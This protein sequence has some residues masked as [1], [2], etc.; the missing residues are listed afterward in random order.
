MSGELIRT[1]HSLEY[2]V[3]LEECVVYF[4]YLEMK[5]IHS[6][7]DGRGAFVVIIFPFVSIRIKQGMPAI[8]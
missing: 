6:G 2:D 4:R 8:P 7:S 3:I 1:C 5:L